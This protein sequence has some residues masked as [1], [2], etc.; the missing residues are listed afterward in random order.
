MA[1][2]SSYAIVRPVGVVLQRALIVGNRRVPVAGPCA[3]L[4][5]PERVRAPG[6]QDGDSQHQQSPGEEHNRQP[7]SRGAHTPSAASL[8][9]RSVA[10][11]PPSIR[12]NYTDARPRRTMR[13]RPSITSPR[14]C[15]MRH[16]G[17]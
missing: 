15:P 1:H 2:S 3:L 12:S 8:G 11:A 9:R 14:R 4:A 5:L 17:S 6:H 10:C 13:Y 16:P 7:P